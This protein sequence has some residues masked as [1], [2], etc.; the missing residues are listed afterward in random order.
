M[1]VVDVSLVELS[2]HVVQLLTAALEHAHGQLVVGPGVL[3]LLN[4]RR[5]GTDCL[6]HARHPSHE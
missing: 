1:G 2:H 4:L 6:Q 5:V 3:N